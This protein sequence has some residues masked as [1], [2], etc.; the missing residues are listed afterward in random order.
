M[1]S[2]RK[3]SLVSVIIPVYKT[4][5]YVKECIASVLEQDYQNIEVILVDDGSPDHCPAVCE[6]YAGKYKN[7]QV[8]HCYRRPTPLIPFLV[9]KRRTKENLHS[10]W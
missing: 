1:L 6:D 4:E 10:I 9:Q 8:I 7:I 3:L 2:D 5:R